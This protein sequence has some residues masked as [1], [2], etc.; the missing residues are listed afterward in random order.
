LVSNSPTPVDRLHHAHLGEAGEKYITG[1]HCGS[2]VHH[3]TGG[4]PAVGITSLAF[5]WVIKLR[6]SGPDYFVSMTAIA[7]NSTQ[8]RLWL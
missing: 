8:R 6:K 2:R 1:C 5:I 4:V 7:W 3:P